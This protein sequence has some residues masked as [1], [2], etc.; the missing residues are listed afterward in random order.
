K[1]DVPGLHL[2]APVAEDELGGGRWADVDVF[3]RDSNIARMLEEPVVPLEARQGLDF[4]PEVALIGKAGDARQCEA[5]GK[6]PLNERSP[7]SDY[8]A[9]TLVLRHVEIVSATKGNAIIVDN[10]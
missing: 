5:N 6:R 1:D 2:P 10:A 8:A 7:P 9:P 4:E 3:Q